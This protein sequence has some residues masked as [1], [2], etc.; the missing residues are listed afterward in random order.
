MHSKPSKAPTSSGA[1]TPPLA[2]EPSVDPGLELEI[3]R[4]TKHADLPAPSLIQCW[5]QAALRGRPDAAEIAIRLV[6]EDE[7]TQL[8]EQYR[9]GTGPTDVLSFPFEAPPG[10]DG[11]RL[12]GDLVICAPVVA[13]RAVA[14]GRQPTAHWAHIVVHGVLHLLGY[15]HQNNQEAAAMESLEDALLRGLGF[16]SPYDHMRHDDD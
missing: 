5:V 11:C 12:L 14:L 10:V 16:D 7:M 13:E 9:G 1:A 4:A 3:Q 2:K 15:D 6:D 8:N